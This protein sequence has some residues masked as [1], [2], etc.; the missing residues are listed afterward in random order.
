M[1]S[2]FELLVRGNIIAKGNLPTRKL[3]RKAVKQVNAGA[4]AIGYDII[5]DMLNDEESDIR[6]AEMQKLLEVPRNVTVEEYHKIHRLRG[7]IWLPV[8]PAGN[9]V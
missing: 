7:T 1:A 5:I 9:S 8:I 4:Q 3:H 2:V 6:R